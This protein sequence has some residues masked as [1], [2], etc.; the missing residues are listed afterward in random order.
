M[1]ARAAVAPVVRAAERARA[2]VARYHCNQGSSD[3]PSKNTNKP[4]PFHH[5]GSITNNNSTYQA[6]DQCMGRTAGNT[7]IPGKQVPENSCNQGC[8]NNIRAYRI[9]T[10][11]AFSDGSGYGSTA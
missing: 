3:Q 4:I 10:N 1:R 8:D 6:T 5:F 9:Y 2:A 7:E 11:N